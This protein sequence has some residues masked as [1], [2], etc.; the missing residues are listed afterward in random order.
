[1]TELSGHAAKSLGFVGIGSDKFE[2]VDLTDNYRQIFD[3]GWPV[4][5]D[6]AMLAD[7]LGITK[8]TLY[9]VSSPWLQ[10]GLDKDTKEKRTEP[11]YKVFRLKKGKNKKTGKEMY[12]FIQAPQPRL[13]YVQTQVAGRILDHVP[14]PEYITGFRKGVGMRDTA[15]KHSGK[16]IVVSLDIQNF[17][18][19]IK[20][21][22]LMELFR[23]Y[24][25]YP[26]R[27]SKILSEICT[28]KYFVPQGA[29]SSPVL[30][31]IVGYYFFDQKVDLIAKKYGFEM[32]R[33]ADDITLSTDQD[34][35]KEEKT[36]DNG[37]VVVTSRI[38]DMIEEIENVLS[39]S[40]FK[41]NKYK[42]K[43][44]RS[45]ARKW[46]LGQVVN[47]EPNILRRDFNVL[48]CIVHNIEVT[49]LE[50][51]ASR[52]GMTE[53][54]FLAWL[55]GKLAHLKQVNPRKGE[56]L[57]DRLELALKASGHEENIREVKI[58]K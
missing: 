38:D 54:Q 4:I 22:H 6:D 35:P 50:E 37:T 47:E 8:R 46:V 3:K 12:R 24:F 31:N 18:N 28:F 55:R 23:S 36:L 13:K 34:Y 11:L 5:L 41:L 32:T 30:S 56:D 57:L 19:S 40:G 48:R 53:Y 1:M 17:F 20:Q 26:R 14:L 15:K 27:V 25:H 7:S 16:K 39:K 9:Y 52:K 42:T 10:A 44:M 29:P 51:Q 49:S 45:P 58:N 43:V 2:V 21:T 33:Y